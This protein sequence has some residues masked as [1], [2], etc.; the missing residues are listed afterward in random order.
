MNIAK[1]EDRIFTR[2]RV[3]SYVYSLF[4]ANLAAFGIRLFAGEWLFDRKGNIAF[5]DFLQWWLGGRVARTQGADAL[6]DYHTFSAA[7][8]LVTKAIP[9]VEY[10]HWVFPPTLLL[11]VMPIARLPY[12]M[13]FIAWGAATLCIYILGLYEILPYLVAVCAALLP[14]PVIKNA[15][16]GQTAFLMTGLLAL[17]LASIERRPYLSGLLLALLIYKPQFLLFFP[18]ALLITLQWRVIVGA[19]VGG[20]LYAGVSVLA[21]GYNAWLLFFRSLRAHNPATLLP[22]NQEG[23]NQT[24]FGLMHALGAGVATAWAAHVIVAV[25]TTAI[26]CAVWRLHAPL[27]LKAAAFAVGALIVT[28]YMLAYDLTAIV[29]PAAFIVSDGL[30]NGFMPGERV[31]LTACFIASFLCFNA[32]IGPIILLAMM[33]LIIRRTMSKSQASLLA[34]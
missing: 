11:L 31:V 26:A 6:Y 27:A 10:Y 15:F 9:K 19:G 7:Q 8:A 23:L 2:Q 25:A 5:I 14:L 30:T 33:W 29:V 1:L 3:S 17:S 21:F 32:V 13:A 16:D 28:P 24:V 12:A 34:V 20:L 4:A 22:P 18:V